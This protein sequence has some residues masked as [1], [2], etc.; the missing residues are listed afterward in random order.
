AEQEGQ[1]TETEATGAP[2][3][4]HYT[5]NQQV[6]SITN[7]LI[8]VQVIQRLVPLRR[9]MWLRGPSIGVCWPPDPPRRAYARKE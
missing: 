3:K 6:G 8:L 5:L 2:Q 1:Q 9:A 4:H 7:N